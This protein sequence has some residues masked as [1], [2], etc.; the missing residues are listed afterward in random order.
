MGSPGGGGGGNREVGTRCDGSGGGGGNNDPVGGGGKLCT[1]FDAR[2]S[3]D[4][5]GTLFELRFP[6]SVV[7]LVFPSNSAIKS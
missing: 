5:I 4:G 3:V 7:F 2:L 6:V 1:D